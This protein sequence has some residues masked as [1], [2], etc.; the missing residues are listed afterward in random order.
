MSKYHA[1][2]SHCYFLLIFFLLDVESRGGIESLDNHSRPAAIS[3]KKKTMVDRA[4]SISIPGATITESHDDPGR[5]NLAYVHDDHN[6]RPLSNGQVVVSAAVENDKVSNQNGINIANLTIVDSRNHHHLQPRRSNSACIDRRTAVGSLAAVRRSNSG[7]SHARNFDVIPE[8]NEKDVNSL[9]VVA[10]DCNKA[11]EK[12]RSV[13]NIPKQISQDSDHTLILVKA[14]KTNRETYIPSSFHPDNIDVCST[15]SSKAN[16][17]IINNPDIP[18]TYQDNPPPYESLGNGIIPISL[19]GG[20]EEEDCSYY[21]SDS[22][23]WS[24]LYAESDIAEVLD[25]QG[26]SPASARSDRLKVPSGH[27][28]RASNVSSHRSASFSAPAADPVMVAKPKKKQSKKSAKVRKNTKKKEVSLMSGLASGAQFGLAMTMQIA[29]QGSKD[30]IDDTNQDTKVVAMDNK[31]DGKTSTGKSRSISENQNEKKTNDSVVLRETPIRRESS[32]RVTV[33][34][35]VDSGDKLKDQVKQHSRNSSAGSVSQHS[36]SNDGSL[37]K[38]T[39][40]QHSRNSSS[41]GVKQHSRHSSAGFKQHSR[42]SST[43]SGIIT[44]GSLAMKESISTRYSYNPFLTDTDSSYVPSEVNPAAFLETLSQNATEAADVSTNPFYTSPGDDFS[45]YSTVGD[46]DQT[47]SIYGTLGRRDVAR[48]DSLK[49]RN[50]TNPFL[51]ALDLQDDRS[52]QAGSAVARRRQTKAR[53]AWRSAVVA[54]SV[55]DFLNQKT[56]DGAVLDTGDPM[57]GRRDTHVRTDVV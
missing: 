56:E 31:D 3:V 35:R 12:A 6:T 46:V 45:Y 4:T 37:E 25:S 53:R 13:K 50:S 47:T 14:Q 38:R 1:C 17:S 19:S 29:K 2:I 20:E 27:H 54:I 23:A 26:N 49:A 44:N 32:K 34:R 7:G 30:S 28:R 40:K 42:Q 10:E 55:V 8:V 21:D 51:H 39:S 41:G 57:A 11:K 48:N 33:I 43:G 15:R 52:T 16:S 22:E 9:V 24:N 36:I 18:D 5:D